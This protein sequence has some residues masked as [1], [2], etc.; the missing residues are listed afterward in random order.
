MPNLKPSQFPPA[1]T[2]FNGSEGLTGVQNGGDAL[3]PLTTLQGPKGD[4][5]SPGQTVQ[6]PPGPPGTNPS[7]G[8]TFNQSGQLGVLPANSWLLRLL[9]RN[10]TTTAVNASVGT[11][12]GASDVLAATAVPTT[13]AKSI[14]VDITSF[15]IGS[16]PAGETQ[17]LYLTL[18]NNASSVNAQLDYEP[19]P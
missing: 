9:L 14:T 5:G 4:A 13:N 11:T 17:T 15:A 8:G 7:L 12:L 10:N 2:P 18:S 6:G 16:F 3:F 1:K 19:G